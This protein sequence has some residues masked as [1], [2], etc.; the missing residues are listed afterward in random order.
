M[1]AAG[2]EDSAKSVSPGRTMALPKASAP[3]EK[4]ERLVNVFEVVF[5]MVN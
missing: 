4:S 3:L 1:G 5:G 2:A